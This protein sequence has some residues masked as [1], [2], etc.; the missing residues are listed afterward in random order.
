[1]I[2]RILEPEVMEA[3][4]EAREYDAMDHGAV[5]EAFVDGFLRALQEGGLES[6]AADWTRPLEVLDCGTG[7]ALIPI[8]LL[9]RGV[10]V[11]VKAVDLSA[12]MLKIAADNV[13]RE[14]F[15]RWI[16]LERADCKR[17][18]YGAG[19]FDAVMSNSIVH[20]LAEPR[21]A[22]AEMVRVLKPGGVLFVRD[23]LR[24]DT[25]EKIGDLVNAY[26][27]DANERQRALFRN[28]L[29]AALT[30]EEVRAL[31]T[32]VGLPATMVEQTSDRHWTI[33][34]AIR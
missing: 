28:S 14:R 2:P 7:T 1:M 13:R 4:E 9:R 6:Q 19:A 10:A 21:D 12:E 33:S 23:V 11:Q 18:P 24:P 20:H 8:A 25:A 27:A 22:L 5:N 31:L 26:A 15:E 34:G 32:A 29:H 16:V 30:L 3:A 17:L